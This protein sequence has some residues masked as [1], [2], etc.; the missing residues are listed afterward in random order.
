M[1]CLAPS[2]YT[3]GFEVVV[4][5]NPVYLPPAFLFLEG[6]ACLPDHAAATFVRAFAKPPWVA[7]V[8]VEAL[9]L[10]SSPRLGPDM[11]SHPSGP[12][13]DEMSHGGAWV[14]FSEQPLRGW[15]IGPRV[16]E[17]LLPVSRTL[18]DGP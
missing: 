4:D 6:I 11:P 16:Q 12:S 3:S 8:Q 14:W 7:A 9:S 15:V 13:K 10:H 17:N 18:T 1:I 5:T 2:S